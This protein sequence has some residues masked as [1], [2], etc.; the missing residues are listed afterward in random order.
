MSLPWERRRVWGKFEES[1][2]LAV[3]KIW[4]AIANLRQSHLDINMG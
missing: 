3:G 1:G 4:R 2:A